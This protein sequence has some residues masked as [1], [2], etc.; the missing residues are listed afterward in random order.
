MQSILTYS[1]L[2]FFYL[3][4]LYY[5]INLNDQT[6][7]EYL[8]KITLITFTYKGLGK[9]LKPLLAQPV[10]PLMIKIR[11]IQTTKQMRQLRFINNSNQLNTFWTI[12]SPIFRSTRLCVTVC[13]IKHP[14]CCRPVAWKRRNST[15]RLPASGNIVGA[16]YHK[17]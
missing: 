1:I 2:P 5:L 3:T 7:N 10:L 14:R 12:I 6:N 4:P 16:L 15:S 9:P 11:I 17:L 8:F 13:G